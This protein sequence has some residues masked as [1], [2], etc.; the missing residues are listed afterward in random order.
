M[1][2]LRIVGGLYLLY[3]AIRSWRGA[4][5]TS[6]SDSS[7][8]TGRDG[9]DADDVGI[10]D[11]SFVDAPTE[12]LPSWRSDY[13]QGVV[14][15]VS[16]PKVTLFF[17]AFLPSFVDPALGRPAAQVFG[18]GCAFA[19]ITATV[20]GTIAMAADQLRQRFRHPGGQHPGG[21]HPG[22]WNRVLPFVSAIV[23]GSIALH[24]LL[25]SHH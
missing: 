13:V 21:Q 7:V 14:M 5:R 24:L 25:F 18:Y 9:V 4:S 17:L 22:G 23:L 8:D 16:N 11:P 1:R 2:L 6:P 19:V 15:N 12:K 3:L 20:F 10:E